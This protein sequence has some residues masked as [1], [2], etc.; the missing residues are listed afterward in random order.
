MEM[1]DYL[2]ALKDWR[3][4][5]GRPELVWRAKASGVS[6]KELEGY[7]KN[8]IQLART[9]G[10]GKGLPWPPEDMP[11]SGDS[12]SGGLKS[13]GGESRKIDETPF[14][15]PEVCKEF[16]DSMLKKVDEIIRDAL[17][18]E[19][20]KH[21]KHSV[22]GGDVELVHVSTP[23]GQ[24]PA[25]KSSPELD[26]LPIPVT[27]DG[28]IAP[29]RMVEPDTRESDGVAVIVNERDLEEAA[30]S[31]SRDIMMEL[32]KDEA[33]NSRW[34]G[35]VYRPQNNFTAG[36]LSPKLE[37]EVAETAE[38]AVGFDEFGLPVRL[39]EE[40][41]ID[42]LKR[43]LKVLEPL[44]GE[45]EDPDLFVKVMEQYGKQVSLKDAKEGLK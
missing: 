38:Q 43:C 35:G 44:E 37:S 23:F 9:W 8:P 11:V 22:D 25:I 41:V 10:K 30:N 20:E 32:P 42:W 6:W 21:S 4:Q 45:I 26:P 15:G 28:K 36:D 33:G 14:F 3:P 17:R 12:I 31:G 2:V 27:D 19:F 34:P 29:M 16:R 13:G 5:M 7:V 40:L 1:N 39:E 24:A 18:D